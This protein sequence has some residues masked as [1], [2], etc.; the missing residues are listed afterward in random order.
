MPSSKQGITLLDKGPLASMTDRE[1]INNK[2][3]TASLLNLFNEETEV[4]NISNFPGV[5]CLKI[6]FLKQ[7]NS[8]PSSPFK[9]G[10]LPPSPAVSPSPSLNR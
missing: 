1:N 10:P 9:F 8:P 3:E 7:Q 4:L 5:L 6:P 2:E